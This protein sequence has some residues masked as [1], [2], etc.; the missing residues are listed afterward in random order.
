[1]IF[2]L[3]VIAFNSL[4][5]FDTVSSVT[6]RAF[7]PQKSVPLFSNGF[8]SKQVKKSKPKRAPAY[9]DAPGKWPSK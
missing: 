7:N 8:V 9:A 2:L 1:M 4:Q 5:C 6:R 3:V